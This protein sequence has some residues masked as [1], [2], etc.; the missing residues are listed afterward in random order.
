MRW[1]KKASHPWMLVLTIPFDENGL[2]DE[3][4]ADKLDDLEDAF[5]ERLK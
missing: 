2:P 4:T 5:M 1:D 3:Q